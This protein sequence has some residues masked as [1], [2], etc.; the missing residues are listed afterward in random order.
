MAADWYVILA[1]LVTLWEVGIEVLFAVKLRPETCAQ[2]DTSNIGEIGVHSCMPARM[3]SRQALGTVGLAT[4]SIDEL[5][6]DANL[7][8]QLFRPPGRVIALQFA[9]NA[10]IRAA[11]LRLDLRTCVLCC[12]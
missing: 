4:Q 5:L 2:G 6:L 1:D 9:D 12:C 11:A 10:Y 3:L 7:A 8:G